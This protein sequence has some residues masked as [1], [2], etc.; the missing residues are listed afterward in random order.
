MNLLKKIKPVL[1]REYKIHRLSLFGSYARGDYTEQ[2]D[3]DVLVDVDGKIG[4]E[5]VTLADVLEKELGQ[6]TDV[7]SYRAVSPRHLKSIQP[8][9]IDV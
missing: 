3:V 6:K 2:S 9:L 4:L 7:I 8:D 5:F 1:E